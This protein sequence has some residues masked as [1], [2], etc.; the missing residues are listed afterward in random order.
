MVGMAS[1][2]CDWNTF[3]VHDWS[4]LH[5]CTE[6]DPSNILGYATDTFLVHT[7]KSYG[8]TIQEQQSCSQGSGPEHD[9]SPTQS[10]DIKLSQ[11]VSDECPI[12]VQDAERS[13]YGG[14]GKE[15]AAYELVQVRT[16]I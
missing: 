14:Y 16:L 6:V 13:Y 3:L 5:P 8:P 9:W 11:T 1:S 2:S 10:M 4:I 12:V 15:P 7:R